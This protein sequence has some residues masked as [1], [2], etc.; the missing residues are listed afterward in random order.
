M[1]RIVLCCFG[2]SCVSS[3]RVQIAT[4]HTELLLRI[5]NKPR[6]IPPPHR[7]AAFPPVY[8]S[9]CHE[10]H[11]TAQ[12]C[13]AS[14][15]HLQ[16]VQFSI[17]IH[18][19]SAG[20][21][22]LSLWFY[23]LHSH[24]QYLPLTPG[25]IQSFFSNSHENSELGMKSSPAMLWEIRVHGFSP[26]SSLE[27]LRPYMLFPSLVLQFCVTLLGLLMTPRFRLIIYKHWPRK[28]ASIPRLVRV[29]ITEIA[30]QRLIGKKGDRMKQ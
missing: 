8:R 28:K 21:Y 23:L 5:M 17:T 19:G 13:D 27:L 18:G 4:A 30:S 6:K 2:E 20:A 7:T 16:G 10:A 9:A 1:G 22:L 26:R 25:L 24:H 12:E 29:R 14:Q 11:C 3:D 15:W